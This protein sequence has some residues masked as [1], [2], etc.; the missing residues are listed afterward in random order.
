VTK[1]SIIPSDMGSPL[2]RVHIRPEPYNPKGRSGRPVFGKYFSKAFL[3]L[4]VSV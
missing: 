1:F 4:L 3:V 2:N